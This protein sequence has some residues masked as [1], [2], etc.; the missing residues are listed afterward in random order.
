MISLWE[1]GGTGVRQWDAAVVVCRCC[2]PFVCRIMDDGC[3]TWKLRYPWGFQ[4]INDSSILGMAGGIC[5]FSLLIVNVSTCAWFDMRDEAWR[6]TEDCLFFCFLPRQRF[7]LQHCLELVDV[8]AGS[9]QSRVAGGGRTGKRRVANLGRRHESKG[10]N[11][12]RRPHMLPFHIGLRVLDWSS[13]ALQL[14][15]GMTAALDGGGGGAIHQRDRT[16]EAV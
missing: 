16:L 9:C 10:Q 8:R 1:E 3:C 12:S 6:Q 13:P 5:G 11:L 2:W 7:P 14:A 4:F 15:G